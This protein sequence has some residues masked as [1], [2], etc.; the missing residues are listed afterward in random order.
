MICESVRT[1]TLLSGYV[2]FN[3]NTIY[4]SIIIQEDYDN[5]LAP[6]MSLGGERAR[7]RPRS[8]LCSARE[9][10]RVDLHKERGFTIIF[11]IGSIVGHFSVFRFKS[12]PLSILYFL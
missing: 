12:S 9:S 3:N 5:T 4:M 10:N 6:D 11:I 8:F 7:E 1:I 2:L